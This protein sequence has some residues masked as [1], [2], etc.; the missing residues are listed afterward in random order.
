MSLSRKQ[1]CDP[2]AVK[3]FARLF[4]L[5]FARE[6]RVLSDEKL[7]FLVYKFL[8]A[9]NMVKSPAKYE[10]GPDYLH[11]VS[12]VTRKITKVYE[13]MIGYFLRFLQI[14]LYLLCFF[15]LIF[16]EKNPQFSAFVLK[17]YFGQN[18]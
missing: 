17:P 18:A 13:E 11:H 16:F 9:E 5:Y 1:Y 14:Y 7:F 15:I 4:T 12:L 10:F 8:W 6:M 3:T 2:W